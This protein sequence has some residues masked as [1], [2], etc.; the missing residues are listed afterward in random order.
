MSLWEVGGRCW[1][2]SHSHPPPNF[3][4]APPIPYLCPLKPRR[5]KKKIPKKQLKI[6]ICRERKTQDISH[7][8][9]RIAFFLT[10]L[11]FLLAPSHPRFSYS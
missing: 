8:S 2:G 3:L 7:F 6:K 4:S 9:Y 1:E 5:L 10:K 11:G